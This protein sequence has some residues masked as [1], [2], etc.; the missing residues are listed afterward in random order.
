MPLM[1]NENPTF[2]VSPSALKALFLAARPKTWIASISPVLIGAKLAPEVDFRIFFHTLF[3]ALFIQIGTNFA[4]DYF[5]FIKGADAKRKGPK[6][7]TQEGWIL[8]S[9]MLQI[10]MATFTL[11]LLMALPL[12]MQVGIWSFPLALLCVACG[13]FY[14]G[15][16]KPL[17][18]LGLGELFVF[19][20]FGP[21][22]VGGTYFLQTGAL[23]PAIIIAGIAPGLFSCALLIA[24]NLRDAE[25]DRQANTWTLVARFGTTFGKLEYLFAAFL[26]CLTP[27]FL[28]FF[29]DYSSSFLFASLLLPF[30]FTFSL[31]STA[32]GFALYTFLFCLA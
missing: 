19:P 15:G 32:L 10:T 3:F 18:Y 28:F 4:N 31:P 9:T 29:F 12:M 27:C 7:A 21:K 8:P 13:I 6:R 22:A 1:K 16:P 26:A 5:D 11:A 30:F 2:P 23:H 17:G 25:T 14:T 20:F 24:N